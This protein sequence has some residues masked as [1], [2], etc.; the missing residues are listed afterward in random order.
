MK[1]WVLTFP[2]MQG[3]HADQETV[4]V[5]YTGT[6]GSGGHALYADPSGRIRVEITGGGLAYLLTG[7]GVPDTPIH[8][9]PLPDAT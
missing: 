6:A 4:V 9:E 3:G 7:D 1:R 5:E 2:G 8:A